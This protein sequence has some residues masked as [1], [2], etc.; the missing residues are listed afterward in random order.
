[1]VTGS[2]DLGWAGSARC[3]RGT[4]PMMPQGGGGGD[5]GGAYTRH[6][7]KHDSAL[8]SRLCL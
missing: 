8:A 4:F 6:N 2:I 7:D 5:A 1:M 3:E